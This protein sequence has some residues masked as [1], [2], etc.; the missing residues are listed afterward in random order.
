MK[1]GKDNNKRISVE[2]PLD[3]RELSACNAALVH[4]GRMALQLPIERYQA[5]LK[6]AKQTGGQDL[7]SAELWIQAQASGKM[8]LLE[9]LAQAARQMQDAIKRFQ[10]K[11]GDDAGP[12]KIIIPGG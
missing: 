11:H 3:P 12:K 2:E 7:N 8:E 1:M 6:A 10:K 4:M 9:R 5:D